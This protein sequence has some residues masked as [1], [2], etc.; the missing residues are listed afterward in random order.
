MFRQKFGQFGQFFSKPTLYKQS[1]FKISTKEHKNNFDHM[2]KKWLSAIT[3]GKSLAYALAGINFTFFLWCNLS[4]KKEKRWA[5]F[6]H[7]S[8]SIESFKNRDYINLFVSPLVS[9][10]VDDLIFDTGILLTLG[11]LKNFKGV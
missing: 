1:H 5:A 2:L 11:K 8:Y 9:R 3:P 6:E 4:T 7:F 10:R